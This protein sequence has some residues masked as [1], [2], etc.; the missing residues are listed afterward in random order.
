M[1]RVK[2]IFTLISCLIFSG[3]HTQTCCSGGIPISNYIGLPQL[4]KSSVQVGLSYDFN[5]LRTLKN[6]DEQLDDRDRTRN[7]HSILLR[8]GIQISSTLSVDVTLPYAFLSRNIHN[9]QGQYDRSRSRGL[10]DPIIL[11]KWGKVL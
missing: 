1:L 9:G 6:G 11:M 10:G 3:A 4:N 2:F 8:G 5:T 7:T